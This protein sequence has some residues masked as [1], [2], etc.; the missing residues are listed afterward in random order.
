[1]GILNQQGKVAH[2]HV[3]SSVMNMLYNRAIHQ[4]VCGLHYPGAFIGTHKTVVNAEWQRIAACQNVLC[5]TEPSAAC[6]Q[7]NLMIT[8]SNRD[9]AIS[10]RQSGR[11]SVTECHIHQRRGDKLFIN[12]TI[13]QG[14]VCQTQGPWAESGVPGY[15]MWLSH[16]GL[17]SAGTI[18]PPPGFAFCSPLTTAI[19]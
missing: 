8:W 12:A 15:F 19:Y 11:S 5:I 2:S 13:T 7:S 9:S 16:P 6:W 18:S 3:P 10:A 14:H 1:M 17:F 4:E